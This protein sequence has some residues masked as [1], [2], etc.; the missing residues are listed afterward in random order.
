MAFFVGIDAGASTTRAVLAS[1]EKASLATGRGARLDEA[2]APVVRAVGTAPCVVHCGLA[3]VSRPARRRAF[4]RRV[5]ELLPGADLTV[6]SDVEAALWGAFPDGIGVVVV[7][8]TGSIA[9]ARSADGSQSRAGG[10]GWLL[11]DEGSA[12]WLGRE[13]CRAALLA[14]DGRGQPT[15][16]SELL[17]AEL[18]MRDAWQ[19]P[20]RVRSARRIA[21]LAPLVSQ[22]ADTGDE[23]AIDL[24]SQAGEILAH[25]AA[26]AVAPR[27]GPGGA[28]LSAPPRAVA[29]CGGVWVA[30]AILIDAFDA[31]LRRELP[32]A[33]AVWPA[34]AAE[35]GALRLALS[36]GTQHLHPPCQ[37]D[38]G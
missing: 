36:H 14:T 35:Y 7:A 17:S 25:L 5:R 29:R 27:R 12:F 38:R 4:E 37:G 19:L 2:L 16:L 20:A 34:Q 26:A 18:D 10:Y 32:G 15:V 13:A 30:G 11:G 6:G 33:L 9:L 1:G 23:V 8:G 28:A 24:L 22:A 3:G 21:S 31:A